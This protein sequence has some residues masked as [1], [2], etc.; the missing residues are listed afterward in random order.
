MTNTPN[1]TKELLSEQQ[2]QQA[3]WQI[4]TDNLHS[5]GRTV[6]G[7]NVTAKV[8]ARLIQEQKIAHGKMLINTDCG[9]YDMNL[10]SVDSY[11]N[12]FEQ[13]VATLQKKQRS[14]NK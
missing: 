5:I 13:G 1:P 9:W 7:K 8:L 12:A 14:R 10:D 6:K 2:L 4:L 3:I 11:D